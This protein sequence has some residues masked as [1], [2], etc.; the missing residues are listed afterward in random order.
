M[1]AQGMV[2]FRLEGTVHNSGEMGVIDL[3]CEL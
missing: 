1:G 2:G 3:H